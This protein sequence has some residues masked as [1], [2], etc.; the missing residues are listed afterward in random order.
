MNMRYIKLIVYTC[1]QLVS[2]Y[3][4]NF[5]YLWVRRFWR[6]KKAFRNKKRRFW[7]I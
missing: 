3:T 5:M 2:G 4:F 1:A 6:K 7:K